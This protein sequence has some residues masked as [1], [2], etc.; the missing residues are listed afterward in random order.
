MAEQREALGQIGGQIG[1][2]PPG[3]RRFTVK[4]GAGGIPS[5]VSGM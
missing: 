3:G 5:M 4:E 1:K 2:K